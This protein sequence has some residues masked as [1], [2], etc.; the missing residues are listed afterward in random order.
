[1]TIL[2]LIS[3][4][5]LLILKALN[6]CLSPTAQNL[7]IIFT[8]LPCFL[9]VLIIVNLISF[10]T[11]NLIFHQ[12]LC[13][14]IDLYFDPGDHHFY[15]VNHQSG[16]LNLKFIKAN[17]NFFSILV[18]K[19]LIVHH[20]SVCPMED[21]IICFLNHLAIMLAMNLSKLALSFF[22]PSI[23]TEPT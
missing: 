5:F 15:F 18:I 7:L 23:H 19:C 17:Q 13:L 14:F 21:P 2:K 3:K 1:L 4:D 16:F 10:L 11:L 22:I 9:N 8:D 20:F 12:S 6:L